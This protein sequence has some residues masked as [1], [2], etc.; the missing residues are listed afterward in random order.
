M[1]NLSSDVIV[2]FAISS[3]AIYMLAQCNVGLLLAIIIVTLIFIL[4][5]FKND[6]ISCISV[7]NSDYDSDIDLDGEEEVD[8][9]DD[10]NNNVKLE[11]KE[12]K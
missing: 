2:K 8:E 10:K 9:D 12:K 7:G 6:V 5:I 1:L 4:Y 11:K 3:L